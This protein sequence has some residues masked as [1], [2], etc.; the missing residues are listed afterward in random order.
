MAWAGVLL[1]AVRRGCSRIR[2]PAGARCRSGRC[3][4]SAIE[5]GDAVRHF[6]VKAEEGGRRDRDRNRQGGGGQAD[7]AAARAGTGRHHRGLPRGEVL[8][9]RGQQG[10]AQS[11]GLVPLSVIV[12]LLQFGKGARRAARPRWTRTRAVAGLVPSSSATR[13]Y[14]NSSTISRR[15]HRAGRS[16]RCSA[17]RRRLRSTV[18]R[19]DPAL[20]VEA[21]PDAE[22][23][24]HPAL[25]LAPP[26]RP[27]HV[28][29]D[30]E[31]P[32]GG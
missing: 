9:R 2:F 15:R 12:G 30:A 17:V 26:H 25:K 3:P 16:A 19:L 29:G 11:V 14:S 1:A 31:E 28:A 5:A 23:D 21:A 8:P 27:Q 22:L 4:P 20:Q 7:P 32:R 10:V 18:F 24:R 6:L 13:S